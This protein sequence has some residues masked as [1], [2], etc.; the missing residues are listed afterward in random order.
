MH[1]KRLTGAIMAATAVT[2]GTGGFVSVVGA[3]PPHQHVVN[4]PAGSHDI[5]SGLCN[6]N[7][8]VET[9]PQHV[10]LHNF[11][12]MIHVGPQGPDGVVTITSAGC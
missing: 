6:G 8:T 10:A 9:D 2:I 1:I 7:F 4:T 5:A 11:H 3:V 12:S